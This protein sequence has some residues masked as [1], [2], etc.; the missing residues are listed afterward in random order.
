MYFHSAGSSST[1]PSGG[2]APNVENTDQVGTAVGTSALQEEK[3][4]ESADGSR[5]SR[6]D[7]DDEDF[8]RQNQDVAK[9]IYCDNPP[10]THFSN[11]D[12]GKATKAE[13]LFYR[14]QCLKRIHLYDLGL[15]SDPE[16]LTLTER[17]VLCQGGYDKRDKSGRVK[18]STRVCNFED[19]ND[20]T[21]KGFNAMWH[22]MIT[23]HF[24]VI[25]V[26]CQTCGHYVR[27]HNMLTHTKKHWDDRYNLLMQ[28]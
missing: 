2:S 13:D 23:C 6:K 11:C 21:H 10:A 25:T 16:E 27:S 14:V 5:R 9:Y 19:C 15:P 18:L 20:R 8:E 22:H 17:K 12:S 28:L 26:K 1:N 3:S 7:R 24:P 4:N